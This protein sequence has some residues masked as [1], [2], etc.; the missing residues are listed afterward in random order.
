MLI[1]QELDTVA[2]Y[3]IDVC[4]ADPRTLVVQHTACSLNFLQVFQQPVH[5]APAI[6]S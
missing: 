2:A 3:K 5:S 4:L 6:T 1:L